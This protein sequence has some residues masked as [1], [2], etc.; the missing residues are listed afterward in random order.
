MNISQWALLAVESPDARQRHHS[1]CNGI[2]QWNVA[3]FERVRQSCDRFHPLLSQ[4]KMASIP[5]FQESRLSPELENEGVPGKYLCLSSTQIHI[6]GCSVV[7]VKKRQDNS[8]SG[9]V[10]R[11]GDTAETWTGK[12]NRSLGAMDGRSLFRL[13]LQVCRWWLELA[14]TQPSNHLTFWGLVGVLIPP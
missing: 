13:R 9:G 10:G 7:A 6:V 14:F 2:E 4:A 3:A 12:A 11:E 1:G 5:G 8:R